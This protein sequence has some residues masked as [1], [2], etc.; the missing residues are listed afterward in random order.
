MEPYSYSQEKA[1]VSKLWQTLANWFRVGEMGLKCDP[2][3]KFCGRIPLHSAC[4]YGHL[5]VVKYFVDKCDIQSRDTQGSTPL[6]LAALY[7]HLELVKYFI[8]DLE[9]DPYCFDFKNR[10]PLHDAC[11]NGH[12]DIVKYFLIHIIVMYKQGITTV[13]HHF[14]LLYC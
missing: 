3:V 1:W 5:D 8:D 2:N 12:L 11:E 4:R 7:G 9:Y 6:H 13:I 14:T 10:T